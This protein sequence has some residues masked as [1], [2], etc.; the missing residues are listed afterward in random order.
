MAEVQAE[1]K[2]IKQVLAGV[3]GVEGIGISWDEDGEPVVLI[4]VRKDAG[5]RIASLL[6]HHDLSAPVMYDIAGIVTFEI[7]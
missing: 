6:D 3:D 5:S 2:Y 7:D 1:K 4:R